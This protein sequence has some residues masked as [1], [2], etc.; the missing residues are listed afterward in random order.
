MIGCYELAF[1]MTPQ[2]V[3]EVCQLS[4]GTVQKFETPCR[5]GSI[6]FVI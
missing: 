3:A 5:I 6:S 1:T 4:P 2:D